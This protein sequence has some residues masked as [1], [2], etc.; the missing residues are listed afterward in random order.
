MDS[1]DVETEIVNR[2]IPINP[3]K[4]VS[5]ESYANGEPHKTVICICMNNRLSSGFRLIVS[6]VISRP[7][8]DT[9]FGQNQ[10]GK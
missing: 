2:L 10:P 3:D 5:F 4:I 9:R 6:S 8:L 7:C 1:N